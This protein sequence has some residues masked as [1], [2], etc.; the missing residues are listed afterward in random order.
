VPLPRAYE[1]QSCPLARSLEIVGERWTL[2]IL[3]DLFFGVRRFG[4]LQRR[5][6]IPRAVLSARLAT[7]VESGLVERRPYRPG[8]DE[9]LLTARAR[10]LWP[11]VYELMQWGERH[12][13]DDGP[14]R[15]F[16]HAK[17]GT[18][19]T[20]D[21]HCPECNVEPEPGDVET[22]PGPGVPPVL[23]DDAVSR[24]LRRPHRLLTPV[25]P[26]PAA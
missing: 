11:V 5:L 16:S 22:R 10:E 19:L 3:R 14:L 24:A 7:L 20:R 26:M 13:V 23:R 17:C 4:E 1:G 9:L 8:R 18:T 12:L 2:L 25:E 6:D 15:L 21:G